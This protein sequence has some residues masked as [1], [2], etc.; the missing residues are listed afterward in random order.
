MHTFPSMFV[1]SFKLK[2]KFKFKFKLSF[3]FSFEFKFKCVPLLQ[4]KATQQ[5]E[6]L[7]GNNI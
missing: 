3:K 1:Y 7:P 6:E 2:F 5:S 4:R